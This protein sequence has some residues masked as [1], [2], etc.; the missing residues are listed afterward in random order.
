MEASEPE[1]TIGEA[2]DRAG[3][4][5]SALRYWERTGLLEAPVRRGGRRRYD[6]RALRRIEAVVRARRAGFT[7]AETRL[8]VAGLAGA[9]P[10]R[11]VWRQLAAGRLPAIERAIA[12]ALAM[13]AIL[14]RGLRCE[15]VSI[16]RCLALDMATGPGARA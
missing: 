12:E 9:T 14:E 6:E 7:L 11:D 4:A 3:V 10:P 5:A 8:V 1:L 15:C 13:R 16:E 2:A